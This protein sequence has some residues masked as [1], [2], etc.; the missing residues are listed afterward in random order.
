MAVHRVLQRPD[1]IP[2]ALQPVRGSQ[3]PPRDRR[4]PQ[5]ADALLPG[6]LRQ[7]GNRGV[8]PPG[9]PG[10]AGQVE[11]HGNAAEVAVRNPFAA[12]QRHRQNLQGLHHLRGEGKREPAA[13]HLH[14][15]L[16]CQEHLR[17]SAL[18][19]ASG[20]VRERA[21][22]RQF[23]DQAH[24]LQPGSGHFLK[25]LRP[26]LQILPA[27]AR[28]QGHLRQIMGNVRQGHGDR[29]DP[30]LPENPHRLQ[31][32]IPV[33]RQRG[34]VPLEQIRMHIQTFPESPD[35]NGVDFSV[36]LPQ[37]FVLRQIQLRI[38]SVD[39]LQRD[40]PGQKGRRI[41]AGREKEEDIRLVSRREILQDGGFPGLVAGGGIIRNRIPRLR[42]VSLEN[43][44]IGLR[45]GVRSRETA[46]RPQSHAALRRCAGG[47]ERNRQR[48]EQGRY[49]FDAHLFPP[50]I[51]PPGEARSLRRSARAR[52]YQ[53]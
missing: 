5:P 14:G 23:P 29:Y 37:H 50:P 31:Q 30:V 51:E 15:G 9:F 13:V 16:L 12:A 21:R 6:Q 28:Q 20:V 40:H 1:H 8:T 27:G 10:A 52:P 33:R 18:I 39:L 41:G 22:L 34:T 11:A 43:L 2:S 17:G 49:F 32:R 38:G 46:D 53:R 45:R 7:Q 3:E 26:G 19:G 24:G 36:R 48:G 4:V 25:G 47:K 42:F 35:R 44:H